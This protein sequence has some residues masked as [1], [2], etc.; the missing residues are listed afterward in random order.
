M[1]IL[2]TFSYFEKLCSNENI[3]RSLTIDIFDRNK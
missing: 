2:K 3:Y 1:D